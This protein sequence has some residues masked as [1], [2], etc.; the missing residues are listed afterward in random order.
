MTE[1]E[2][3]KHTCTTKLDDHNQRRR[4]G[5][6]NQCKEPAELRRKTVANAVHLRR[7]PDASPDADDAD[8]AAAGQSGS[9][10]AAGLSPLAH[11]LQAGLFDLG[12]GLASEVPCSEEGPHDPVAAAL[13]AFDSTLAA[14]A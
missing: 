4:V 11:A 12:D 14:V 2:G 9:D 5:R 10:S 8:L 13:A 3:T 7:A 1:F 6:Q